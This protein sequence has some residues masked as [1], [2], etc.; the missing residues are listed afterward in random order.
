[1][2]RISDGS[3]F[4]ACHFIYAVIVGAMYFVTSV[5]ILTC[6]VGHVS[7]IE[8]SNADQ[9]LSRKRSTVARVEV[10]HS[11]WCLLDVPRLARLS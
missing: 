11:V 3:L 5:K 9:V 6:I 10:H 7:A 1:M 8:K 4:F 2:V